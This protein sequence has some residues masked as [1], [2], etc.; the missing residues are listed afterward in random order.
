MDITVRKQNQRERDELRG[1]LMRAQEDDIVHA[2]NTS[3]KH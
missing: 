1:H 2:V 3:G